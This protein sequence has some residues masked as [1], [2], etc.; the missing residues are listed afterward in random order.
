[1][2]TRGGHVGKTRDQRQQYVET[3]VRGEDTSATAPTSLGDEDAT[4]SP[5]SRED[6]AATS[7]PSR[8]RSRGP[9]WLQENKRALIGTATRLVLVS[10][11]GSA[12][13]LIEKSA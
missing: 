9:T 11:C 12:Q 7:R 3:V 10:F 8:R 2:A 6:R 4:N 5:T 13:P 1:M